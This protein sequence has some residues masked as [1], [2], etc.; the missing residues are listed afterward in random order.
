MNSLKWLKSQLE[1]NYGNPHQC[2]I[3]WKDLDE[4]LKQTEN[5]NDIKGKIFEVTEEHL[6][7]LKHSHIMWRASEYGAPMIDPKR[8]YG[9][10]SVESDIA[11]IL[12]WDKEDS[13]R[14]EKLHR[15][16]EIV[17]QIVL[18]TQT[19]EPGLYNIRNEYTTD[20]IKL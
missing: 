18:V 12:G 10:T 2:E 3:E 16:L 19:F 11:E 5:L 8:P 1:N 9:N 17:L 6:K 13:Q 4:L 7:L 20:W 15:E 14:A